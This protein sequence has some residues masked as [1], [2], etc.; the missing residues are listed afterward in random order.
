MTIAATSRPVEPGEKAFIDRAF[1]FERREAARLG[2]RVRAVGISLIAATLVFRVSG[3]ALAYYV[4]ILALLFATGWLYMR[5][6]TGRIGLGGRAA[7]LAQAALIALDMAL[8]TAALV[9]PSPAAPEA[10]P[11][12]MQLR[13][14]NVGFLFVFLAFSALTYSPALALWAGFAAGAAWLGGVGWLLSRPETFTRSPAAFTDMPTWEIVITLLSPHYVSTIAAA[15]EA[16]LLT[17]VGAV[18]AAAVWRGR[19]Q[20]L[21]QIETA[22]ERAKLSR[23]FS[24]DVV[25]ELTHRPAVIGDK[26]T[27]NAAIVF[28]DIVGFTR[29][30][31]TMSPEETIDFLREF[32]RRATGATFAQGGTVNKFIGDEVMI[33]FNAIHYVAEAPAKA[34]ACA[35]DIV[36][37]VATWS[38]EREA[39]G[40]P[41][42]HVGVGVHVG[43]VIVGNIGDERCLE[44]ALLGDVVN[45]ASRFQ[46]LTR[47][48]GVDIVASGEAVAAAGAA[49]AANRFSPAGA[50][51]VRGRRAPVEIATHT[52][53]SEA[54]NAA[55]SHH[56]HRETTA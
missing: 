17:I 40:A 16:F 50:V 36:E 38:E 39:G 11:A 22:R 20:A 26:T 21:R 43:D 30:A 5:A 51:E 56:H 37:R 46:H 44:L 27:R 9:V 24:P 13:L 45:T 48:L 1:R 34:L 14:G 31:E 32:H 29:L 19:R 54:M 7:P 28:A 23:Y 42:V 25:E 2:F 47:S 18:I 15:Q 41:P 55:A 49:E 53:R 35:L 33:S 6:A 12:A 8:I 10:W 52:L 4:G 3:E